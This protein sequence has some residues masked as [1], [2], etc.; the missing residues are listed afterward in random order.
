MFSLSPLLLMPTM[1]APFGRLELIAHL[2][3][4]GRSVGA[5]LLELEALDVDAVDAHDQLLDLGLV[6]VL[7]VEELGRELQ[8]AGS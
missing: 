6:G 5:L 4:I 1:R 8:H 3:E 7:A 2:F